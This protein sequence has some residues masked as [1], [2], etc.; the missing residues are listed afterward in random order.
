MAFIQSQVEANAFAFL[1]LSS[2]G[3]EC[4]G[5]DDNGGKGSFLM[6][7]DTTCMLAGTALRNTFLAQ[8]MFVK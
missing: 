8:N 3:G 4:W 5:K 7:V 1:A 6:S 2:A